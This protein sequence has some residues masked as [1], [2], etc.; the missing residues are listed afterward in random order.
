MVNEIEIFGVFLPEYGLMAAAGLAAAVVLALVQIRRFALDINDFTIICAFSGLMG[1]MGAKLLY[2]LIS[3]P[4]LM[5]DEGMS[6]SELMRGG[7][8][9]YGGFIGFFAGLSL[10][11]KIFRL[12]TEPYLECCMAC[13]PLFHGFGRIGCHLAGCCYGISWPGAISVTYTS[14]PFAPVDI[15]LFPVQLAEAAGEFIIALFLLLT[16]KK[17]GSFSLEIYMLWYGALR[18]GLENFRA[19]QARGIIAGGVSFAQLISLGLMAYGAVRLY[20]KLGT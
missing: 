9:F 18:F 13:F 19:D 10:C 17:T 14:S 5:S 8:V 11:G 6:I 7:F 15:A 4:L 16:Q 20:K 1:L 3:F 2:I 12:N